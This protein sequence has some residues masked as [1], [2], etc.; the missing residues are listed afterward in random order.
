MPD[1]TIQLLNPT[2]Q[3]GTVTVKTGRLQGERGRSV[4]L[5]ATPATGYVFDK[6]EIE[7]TPV[8]LRIF[9]RVG[10]RYDSTN[11][12]CST[13]TVNLTTTLYTDNTLLYTDSEGKY[14]A[15][16]GYWSLG[17]G[18]YYYYNGSTIPTIDVCEQPSGGGTVGG[19]GTRS[20]VFSNQDEIT[21]SERFNFDRTRVTLDTGPN[22]Q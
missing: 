12:V 3:M 22:V 21:D 7:T 8:N 1:T 20:G 13:S 16:T 5:E 6:W 18:Q 4:V 17:N 10:Q 14:P 15:A 11:A 19:G 2:S 9:A